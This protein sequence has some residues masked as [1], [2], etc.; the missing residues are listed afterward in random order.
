MDNATRTI[1]IERIT[2]TQFENTE[3]SGEL[4]EV[5]R[6]LKG[7]VR[8]ERCDTV[9]L[10]STLDSCTECKLQV[11]AFLRTFDSLGIDGSELG[12]PA[13][14][15]LSSLTTRVEET[16]AKGQLLD[17]VM[18]EMMAIKRSAPTRAVT[19]ISRAI[20]EQQQ[21]LTRLMEC[22]TESLVLQ[23]EILLLSSEVFERFKAI[24]TV[25]QELYIY[26]TALVQQ[27]WASM[28]EQADAAHAADSKEA[29][30]DIQQSPSGSRAD[31]VATADDSSAVQCGEGPCDA[32]SSDAS[33]RFDAGEAMQ[34]TAADLH[35]CKTY[36]VHPF[37]THIVMM[38]EN[39]RLYS[40]GWSLC[41]GSSND[42]EVLHEGSTAD[43]WP[44]WCGTK[45]M[46]L[47][48]SNGTTVRPNF[49]IILRHATSM[50]RINEGAVRGLIA[51]LGLGRKRAMSAR[52]QQHSGCK[53][54]VTAT[55][56]HYLYPSGQPRLANE[57]AE[58]AEV[59][60]LMR[61]TLEFAKR[62]RRERAALAQSQQ[63]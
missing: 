61:R 16:I 29:H 32:E 5:H 55:A 6:G 20:D 9:P 54:A 21:R 26:C 58:A 24:C 22:V 28:P 35:P 44:R 31:E 11:E 56:K 36:I 30:T 48:G 38:S 37:K 53:T 15:G 13:L 8:D 62:L 43:E 41:G 23:R 60:F 49:S 4:H 19:S 7:G 27:R 52:A 42:L 25:I 17:D 45:M 39:L 50:A 40:V 14:A 33:A 59:D 46:D 47:H 3:L 18:A 57:G 1:G 34:N 63:P 51:Q 2:N 12:R 10:A